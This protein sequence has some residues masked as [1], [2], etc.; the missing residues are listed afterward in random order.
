MTFKSNG[1]TLH[2]FDDPYEYNCALKITISDL[3]GKVM[4]FN[5]NNRG[6]SINDNV[7]FFNRVDDIIKLIEWL[8]KLSKFDNWEFYMNRNKE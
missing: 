2:S 7:V 1:W 4:R 6:E 8:E 5:N 3:K